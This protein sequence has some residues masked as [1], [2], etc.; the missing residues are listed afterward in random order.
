MCAPPNRQLAV[1]LPVPRQN[2]DDGLGHASSAAPSGCA[3]LL[4]ELRAAV[5]VAVRP[6]QPY[7]RALGTSI[8][9]PG[10][11]GSKPCSKS[12]RTASSLRNDHRPRIALRSTSA[13][14]PAGRPARAPAACATR[15]AESGSA[16]WPSPE[17]HRRRS[18][19]LR[20]AS[21]KGRHTQGRAFMM[22]DDDLDRRPG[23]ARAFRQKSCP[24]KKQSRN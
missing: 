11:D 21:G 24:P 15:P 14:S 18:S 6:V 3:L 4:A 17:P 12:Q 2:T 9:Q 23:Q 1:R 20:R 5:P 19:D 13:P 22:G 10:E 7:S 16:P 8:S